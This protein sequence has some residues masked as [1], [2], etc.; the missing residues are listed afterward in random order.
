MFPVRLNLSSRPRNAFRGFVFA[1]LVFLCM[2]TPRADAQGAAP[3]NGNGLLFYASFNNGCRADVAR[4][5]SLASR[6][7]SYDARKFLKFA[8]SPETGRAVKGKYGS[9]IC[10]PEG[11]ARTPKFDALGNLQPERGTIAFYVKAANPRASHRLVKIG[12]VNNWVYHYGAYLVVR[13]NGEVLFADE[14]AKPLSRKPDPVLAFEPDVWQHVAL[15]W[16]QAMGFR[17]YVNGEEKVSSWGEASWCSRG[18]APDKIALEYR[19]DVSYDELC[20]FDYPLSAGEIGKLR[21]MEDVSA[22]K[23]EEAGALDEAASPQVVRGPRV[24]RVMG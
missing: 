18:V 24:W 14:M 9:G 16:D 6:I 4:G 5:D 7:N 15:V 22:W 2:A 1:L 19:G 20:V 11:R 10:F 3:A 12:V 17:L 13:G 8:P 23:K 21:A